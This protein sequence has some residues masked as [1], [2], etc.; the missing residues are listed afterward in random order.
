M[1][2]CASF[3]VHLASIMDVLTKTAIVEITK[4]VENRSTT[5]Q[6]QMRRG[7]R[8]NEELRNKLLLME[9]ELR[10][11]RGYQEGTEDNSLNMY[12]E[13]Q[14]CNDSTEIKKSE[15]AGIGSIV[16]PDTA[17]T[18]RLNADPEEDDQEV[19]QQTKKNA[20][21]GSHIKNEP[22]DVEPDCSGSPMLSTDELE[23]D[24][25]GS[26]SQAVQ[27]TRNEIAIGTLEAAAATWDEGPLCEEQLNRQPC[28]A[29]GPEK[30]EHTELKQEPED[31]PLIP[32]L[33]LMG[34][35]NSR[36]E[37]SSSCLQ[38]GII[39]EKH[40][41]LG[42]SSEHGD[43]RLHVSPQPL[44]ASLRLYSE[45]SEHPTSQVNRQE[46]GC[47]L[48]ENRTRVL[49]DD[50]WAAP[51]FTLGESSGSAECE[52][53][54]E[55]AAEAI[56][57][58]CI[59][60]TE[61]IRSPPRKT[62][63]GSLLKTHEEQRKLRR[64]FGS[65]ECGKADSSV[66]KKHLQNRRGRKPSGCTQSDK[67]F[68]HQYIPQAHNRTHTETKQCVCSEC[69]KCF[70]YKSNLRIHQR[71]HTRDRPF[72]CEL[73]GKCFFKKSGLSTHRMI[74]VRHP[75]L[76]CAVCNESF[77]YL[78]ALKRHQRIHTGE[79]P[80][81]CNVCGKSFAHQWNLNTHLRVHTGEKPFTCTVCG[82][83]FSMNHSLERHMFTHN[84][85]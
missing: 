84:K 61:F 19:R 64:G 26:K 21:D 10:A 65:P 80:Y 59:E 57:R 9:R 83:S 77:V 27:T 29:E 31:T 3:Q 81:H 85:K 37:A 44:G 48:V 1:A 47:P 69:G 70:Q 51:G 41:G 34:S 67:S 76:T 15:V 62:F 2:N 45:E 66:L 79:K 49:V 18:Q 38:L 6:T 55:M 50:I 75:C 7:Q 58:W 23:G 25:N 78:S 53:N 14:V 63:P 13:V 52:A 43:T 11:V 82:K 17:F 72:K 33:P 20:P 30:E 40:G 46:E 16:A 42:G 24:P 5:L 39:P 8:E 36:L 56:G 71:V 28:S 74:H 35:A 60:G 68:S 12:L 73:C 54:F 22:A 32:A 4:L